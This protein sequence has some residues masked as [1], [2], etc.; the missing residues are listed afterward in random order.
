MFEVHRPGSFSR[1]TSDT[2]QLKRDKIQVCLYDTQTDK[3]K[4][5]DLPNVLPPEQVYFKDKLIKS[6]QIDLSDLMS[7]FDNL[8]NNI[9]YSDTQELFSLIKEL[10]LDPELDEIIQQY[11]HLEGIYNS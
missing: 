10:N 7:D 4:Y 3:V 6:E 1:A 9:T 11:L 8:I 5:L 2:C